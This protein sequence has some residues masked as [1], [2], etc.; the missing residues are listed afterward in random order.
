MATH[1]DLDRLPCAQ[2]AL[3]AGRSG[4]FRSGHGRARPLDSRTMELPA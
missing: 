1:H 4:P 2:A 3:M